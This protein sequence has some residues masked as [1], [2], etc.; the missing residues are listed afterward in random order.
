MC[1]G[2]GKEALH[3]L[4]AF[5]FLLAPYLPLHLR[6]LHS[7]ESHSPHPPPTPV[8]AVVGCCCPLPHSENPGAWSLALQWKGNGGIA[9][10]QVSRSLCQ[11][12]Y[13]D[14]F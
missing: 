14:T 3:L 2:L 9:W 1:L 11:Q 7:L 5:S 10:E 4:S 6:F 12:A 13:W 8:E